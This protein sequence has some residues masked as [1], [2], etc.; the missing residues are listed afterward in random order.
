[1]SGPEEYLVRYA[2]KVGLQREKISHK[3]LDDIRSVKVFVILGELAQTVF[4]AKTVY[5]Y[6]I[7]DE[8]SYNIVIEKNKININSGE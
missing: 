4:F 5:D 3:N 6:E 8:K 1:M 2:N 7:A